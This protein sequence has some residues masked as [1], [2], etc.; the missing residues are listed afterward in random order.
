MLAICTFSSQIC[1]AQA[2]TEGEHKARS[3]AVLNYL[4][5]WSLDSFGYHPAVYMLLEN[6]SG[7]DLSLVTIKMQGKF[8]DIHTLEVS[9]AKIEVRRSLKPHQQFPVALVSPREYE[10]PRDTNFWPV[11]ECKAMARVGTVGDEGTEYLLVTKVE[12]ATATQDESFQKLNE[13]TSFNRSSTAAAGHHHPSSSVPGTKPLLAKADRIGA[14]PSAVSSNDFFGI[15]PMPGLGED[16]YQFEKVFGLPAQ[17]D[18]KRKDYTWA[19]YKQNRGVELIVGSKERSGKVDLIAFV[20]PKDNTGSEQNLINQCKL[21]AGT[22]RN[23]KT[24]PAARSV[25]YLPTG[26]VEITQA[27]GPGL[28]IEAMSTSGESKLIMMT[29][30]S[31]D[32][33]D[34]L[35]S[36]QSGNEV[37]K[38]LPLGD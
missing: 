29:R 10:L 20:L 3:L 12:S 34:L 4:T 32:P 13:L 31:Q 8:T 24:S 21:L 28:R 9:T 23:V 33:S 16:F 11:M 22:Q 26:R 38:S 19:R 25:R 17:I 15:K 30:L 6:I 35:R 37:L 2:E 18:A 27:A 1:Y 5:G 7:R 36:H 14:A